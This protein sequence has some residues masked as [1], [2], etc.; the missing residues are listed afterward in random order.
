MEGVLVHFLNTTVIITLTERILE[1]VVGNGEQTPETYV[2]TLIFY[3]Y[4]NI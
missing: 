1:N 4:K 2:K 3:L